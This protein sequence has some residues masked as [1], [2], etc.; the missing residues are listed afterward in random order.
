MVEAKIKS[1]QCISPAGLHRMSYRE[2]G[3][4]DNPRVL[5]CV[6]GLTRVGADFDILARAICDEVRVICPDVAGRGRSDRLANPALYQVPQYVSDMV[7][8]LARVLNPD[9]VQS[10]DWLGTSMGG[11]IGMGL[12]ALPNTPIKRL[13][14]ND[15]GPRLDKAAMS[16]IGEYLGKNMRFPNFDAAFASILQISL[17]F[18]AHTDAEWRKLVADV[19]VQEAS[20]EWV[21]SYD[22]GLAIPFAN[23]TEQS[24]EYG[25]AALWAAYDAIAC[26]CLVLRGA[27]SDLLSHETALEMTQRGPKAQ[28]IE[29]PDVGHAPMFVHDDQIAII[30]Q[31][32]SIHQRK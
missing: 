10:V 29:L 28:L 27:N 16:R 24:I 21:R 5:L 32:F 20:G 17:P 9:V 18:G 3:D 2:W 30:K 13:V 12:A 19:V 11:L 15:V 14:L 25:Q 4:P 8:L 6:H 1:V 26:P 31:F 23:V 22:P 7:T